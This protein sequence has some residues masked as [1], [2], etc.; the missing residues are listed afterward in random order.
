MTDM[1]SIDELLAEGRAFLDATVRPAET[2]MRGSSGV[3]A[4]TG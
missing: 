2:P 1:I 4:A 3:R